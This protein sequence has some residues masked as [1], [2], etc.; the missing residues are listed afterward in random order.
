MKVVLFGAGASYGSGQVIPRVPPLGNDLFEVL[1]RLYP[2]SWGQIPEKFKT[3]F[4]DNFEEGM[5]EVIDNGYAT[6]G[7]LMQSM[8][9]FFSCF[10]LTEDCDNLYINFLKQLNSTGILK[11]VLISTI[12]YE[13]LIEKAANLVGLPVSYFNNPNDN[14][15]SLWK[16][17]GSCNFKLVGIEATRGVII[18]SQNVSFDGNIKALNPGDV[19][20]EF[21][22]NTAFHPSMCLFA[23]D[24]PITIAPS[25]IRGK[26][27]EWSKITEKAEVM[28]VIGVRPNTEDSHIWDAISD[29]EGKLLFIGNQNDFNAYTSTYRMS[30][31]NLYLGNRWH[32]SFNAVLSELL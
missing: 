22:G 19:K 10:H 8:G 26:Q 30:K 15:L 16:I 24:K 17:H 9:I 13:C 31:D 27:E 21:E 11:D 4:S 25:I 28:C 3:V 29:C 12:N 6:I 5:A 20:K 23:K 18:N 32:E 2:N 7:N 1:Y 14:E